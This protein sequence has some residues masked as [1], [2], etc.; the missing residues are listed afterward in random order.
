MRIKSRKWTWIA[1]GAGVV[2]GTAMPQRSMAQCNYYDRT[3]GTQ[4]V[5]IDY[6]PAY[7]GTTTYAMV[8]RPAE[9]VYERSYV[10]PVQQVTRV[11]RREPVYAPVQYQAP[12]VY[13][14]NDYYRYPSRRIYRS[15][16]H[17]RHYVSSLRHAIRDSYYGGHHRGHRR[18]HLYRSHLG[19]GHRGFGLNIFS[20]RH[21]H[22]RRHGGIRFSYRR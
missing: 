13:V 1:V 22:G 3:Y 10:Q 6:G 14:E 21:H 5:R 18:A 12:V 8:D 20:G 15:S 17:G 11:V 7:R 2:A 9:V 16:R 19:Y 4:P